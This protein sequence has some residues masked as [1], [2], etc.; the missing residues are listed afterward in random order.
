MEVISKNILE[1][2]KKRRDHFQKYYHIC[3]DICKLHLDVLNKKIDEKERST[4]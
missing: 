3:P 4:K 1:S 2:M